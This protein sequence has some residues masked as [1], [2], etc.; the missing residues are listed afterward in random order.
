M[1]SSGM[2]G[3]LGDYAKDAIQTFAK[4]TDYLDV[5]AIDHLTPEH[6]WNVLN[7]A[8]WWREYIH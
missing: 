1:I 2:M 3:G 4:N 7:L 8:L 6:R 5:A